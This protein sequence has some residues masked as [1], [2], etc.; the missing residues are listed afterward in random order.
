[1]AEFAV[2]TPIRIEWCPD[3]C[4][5]AVWHQDSQFP[6]LGQHNCPYHFGVTYSAARIDGKDNCTHIKPKDGRLGDGSST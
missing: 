3:V 4:V 1:M 6:H 5:R 2:E